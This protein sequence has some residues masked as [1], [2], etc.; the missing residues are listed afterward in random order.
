MLRGSDRCHYQYNEPGSGDVQYT[1]DGAEHC[2][3]KDI[4]FNQYPS[5]FKGFYIDNQRVQLSDIVKLL[6]LP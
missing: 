1:R 3:E 6:N 4:E 2:N 5:E